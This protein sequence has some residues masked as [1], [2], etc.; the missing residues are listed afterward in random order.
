MPYT[1]VLDNIARVVGGTAVA[2]KPGLY[3][4][5]R[6]GNDG[7]GVTGLKACWSRQPDTVQELPVGIVL[8]HRATQTAQVQG[9]LDKKDE[10]HLLILLSRNDSYSQTPAAVNFRDSISDAFLAHMQAYAT[11]T[12]IQMF[13]TDFQYGLINYQ[14][15]EYMG[16]HITIEVLRY[17]VATYTA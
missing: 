7:T 9:R 2:S 1:D 5:V 16:W 11:P 14:G 13:P 15:N 12:A 6:N 10:L 17:Q 8:A 3:S 4:G